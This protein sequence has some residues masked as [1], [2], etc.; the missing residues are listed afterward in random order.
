MSLAN[1]FLGELDSLRPLGKL[2]DSLESLDV[3]ANPV[4]DLPG[5]RDS[6]FEW[7]APTLQTID[8]IDREGKE[9]FE[10]S[11]D[12]ESPDKKRQDRR[13]AIEDDDEYDE[14]EDDEEEEGNVEEVECYE[15]EEVGDGDLLDSEDEEEESDIALG[16]RK[17]RAF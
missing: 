12:D 3:S 11:E 14:E 4:A 8:G 2:S 9:V 16:K 7:G 15:E 13:E 5:Y 6:L 1:N 17:E 10:E